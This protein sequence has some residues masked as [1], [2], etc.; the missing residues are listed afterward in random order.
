MRLKSDVVSL[1][2]HFFT[3]VET[4]FGKRIQKIRTDNG[5]EFFNHNC[6]EL[7]QIYGVIHESSCPYTPQQNGVVE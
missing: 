1:L 2:K 5:S 7:F 6:N 3:E 4:Q